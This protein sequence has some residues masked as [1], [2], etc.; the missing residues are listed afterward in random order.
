[1]T[2]DLEFDQRALK[3]WHKLA[4]PGRQHFKSKLS[5]VLLNPALKPTG[6]AS[7]PIA[8]KSSYAGRVTD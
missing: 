1:M 5:E 4:D 3:E 6:C 2:F 8:T 7:C